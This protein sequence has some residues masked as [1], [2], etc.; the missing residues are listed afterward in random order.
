MVRSNKNPGWINWQ[1][2][3]AR[4]IILEDLLPNGRLYGLNFVPGDE[5]FQLYKKW[6]PLAFEKVVFSQFE[7]RLKDHITD[8]A[9]RKEK[10]RE[11]FIWLEHDRKLYP[12]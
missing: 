3:A 12:R 2:S 6:E 11:K 9:V 8:A 5:L 10:A 1:S 4:E 7:A